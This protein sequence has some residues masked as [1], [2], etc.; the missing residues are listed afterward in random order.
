MICQPIPLKVPGI[1]SERLLYPL[2][3]SGNS[4]RVERQTRNLLSCGTMKLYV[5]YIIYDEEASCMLASP[6]AAHSCRDKCLGVYP[7]TELPIPSDIV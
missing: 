2:P 5:V 6:V 3:S 7:A 1:K 4:P